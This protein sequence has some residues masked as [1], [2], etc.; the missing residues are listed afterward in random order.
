M[1]PCGCGS[2]LGAG[3]LAQK[4]VQPVQYGWTTS[5]LEIVLMSDEREGQKSDN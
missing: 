4:P 1:K 2:A 5:E 3:T